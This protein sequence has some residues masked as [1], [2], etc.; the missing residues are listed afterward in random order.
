MTSSPELPDGWRRVKFGDIARNVKVTVDPDE[1]DL[2]RYIAGEHMD[3]DNLHLRR[4]GE[5]GDGYLGPAFHRKFK[6]GQ[7]LYG[8]RRT[9]LRKVAV[10]HFDGVCANTT[11]VIEP[12]GTLIEPD[13]LPFIMQ[14]EGFTEHSIANSKGSVNPYVNWKDIASYE[15]ALPPKDEQ[16]RI[17]AILWA[18][19]DA[20]EQYVSCATQTTRIQNLQFTEWFQQAKNIPDWPKVYLGEV[21]TIQNGQVDPKEMPYQEMIHLAPDD[22]ESETGRIIETNTAAEDGVTSGKYYFAP[23]TIVYSKI[24]PNLRKVAL[25]EFEGICS[26]DVYPVCPGETILLQFLFHLLLSR[27]FTAY[28]TACSVR[29]AIPKIN[30]KDMLEYQFRLPPLDEQR[31]LVDALTTFE[32]ASVA[33]QSHITHIK[34][35]K[36]SVLNSMLERPTESRNV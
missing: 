35:L 25:P 3:T 29:S 26:A 15:F 16:R 7:I 1:S 36:C 19:E 31:R 5:I 14:S 32:S 11:F 4:W 22:I 12:K 2:E 34:K 20:I 18:A 6:L 33:L 13:L 10:A 24:R 8:S 17:A 21:C 30:R 27:E 23:N 28:A 9:Y